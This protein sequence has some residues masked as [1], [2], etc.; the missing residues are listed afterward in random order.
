MSGLPLWLWLYL[1]GALL[2]PGR[3][4][5]GVLYLLGGLFLLAR[6]SLTWAMRRLTVERLLPEERLFAGEPVAVTLRF[7]NP[8]GAP[9]PW[10]QFIES[11]PTGLD[12]TPLSGIVAVE[13]GGAASVSY[14]MLSHR[15]GR[16]LIGPL[17]YAAGDPF[18]FLR[19]EGRLEEP[20]RV[21]V[22]PRV[23]PLPEL[24]L[25]ARLPLGDLATRRRLFEDP[26][27]L[28]GTRPYQQ[29]DS[30]KRIHWPATAKAGALAVKQFRHA[31]LLPAC[32]C[33]NLNREEYDARR[34]YTQVEVAVGAAASLCHYLLERKQQVALL[35]TGVDPDAASLKVALP[36]RQGDAA[37]AEIL[38][39]LARV[40]G[41]VTVDFVTAVMEQAR[42]LPWGTLLCLVTPRETPALAELSARLARGGQQVLLF[43]MQGESVR[44]E[45]Y[46]VWALAEN[47]AGEV[48]VG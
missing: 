42:L 14:T 40:E 26:A 38:E 1:A 22:Y 37:M 18:G 35:A 23:S 9:L 47:R 5:Y 3:P 27:W 15:R 46:Q 43:V 21:T 41:G 30:L 24:G 13:G 12:P 28:A 32:V 44:R 4:L 48:E 36:L 6:L 25:P 7:S 17:A 19:V 29:G 45:S 2:L 34:F 10:V 8:T 31:M 39:V 16:Y 20:T 33:I 11:R